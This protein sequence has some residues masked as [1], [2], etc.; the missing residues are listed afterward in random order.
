MEFS[1]VIVLGHSWSLL[2]RL[3]VHLSFFLTFPLALA[4]ALTPSTRPTVTYHVDWTLPTIWLCLVFLWS[5]Q[6]P[7]WAKSLVNIKYFCVVSPLRVYLKYCRKLFQIHLTCRRC[8]VY[9]RNE[10]IYQSCF[11]DICN[12]GLV[13]HICHAEKSMCISLGVI[14]NA[15]CTLIS[16]NYIYYTILLCIRISKSF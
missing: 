9:E 4:L 11:Y 3:R 1:S 8:I 14:L 2:S 5:I 7:M 6:F 10:H 16:L 13:L 15:N 12:S